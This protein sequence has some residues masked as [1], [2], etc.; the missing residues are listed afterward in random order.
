MLPGS[1]AEHGY[2]YRREEVRQESTDTNLL[3]RPR[4]NLF[5]RMY[6]GLRDKEVDQPITEYK[7]DEFG[8]TICRE[9]KFPASQAQNGE[10]ENHG[11]DK[12]NGKDLGI[13]VSDDTGAFNPSSLEKNP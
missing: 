12:A 6:A 3:A 7:I 1:D 9:R 8:S 2:A 4:A 13:C 5:R 10:I 11:I